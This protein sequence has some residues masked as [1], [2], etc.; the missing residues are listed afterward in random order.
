MEVL[1]NLDEFFAKFKCPVDRMITVWGE[2]LNLEEWAIREAAEEYYER[3]KAC[4]EKETIAPIDISWDVLAIA[5]LKQPIIVKQAKK[6][7][8]PELRVELNRLRGVI[9][10]LREAISEIA[11]DKSQLYAEIDKLVDRAKN[12]EGEIKELR[13]D[14]LAFVDELD[15]V[16]KLI[17]DNDMKTADNFEAMKRD[18]ELE[19]LETEARLTKIEAKSK[20]RWWSS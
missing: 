12:I 1:G 19:R 18:Q 3:Y 14:N 9:A 6:A 16:N 2:R 7:G 11:Q 8:D 15:N 17:T 13:K 20:K 4:K 5:E 10:T